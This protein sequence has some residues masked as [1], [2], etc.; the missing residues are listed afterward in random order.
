MYNP[1]SHPVEATIRPGFACTKAFVT[2][3]NEDMNMAGHPQGVPLHI[4][5]RSGEI[6]TILFQ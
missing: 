6:V 5:L 2:N 3:L 1:L 4:D